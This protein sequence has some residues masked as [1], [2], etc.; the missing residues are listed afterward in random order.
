[1]VQYHVDQTVIK[2]YYEERE[3]ALA[4][5]KAKESLLK[6]F[7]AT[8]LS[9]SMLRAGDFGAPATALKLI[10]V[11][12]VNVSYVDTPIPESDA[13]PDRGVKIAIA[14]SAK[15][16]AILQ[17]ERYSFSWLFGSQDK[18]EADSTPPEI[19]QGTATWTGGIL[20]KAKVVN[21]Q[22]HDIILESLVSDEE[23]R[24]HK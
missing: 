10:S 16:T 17:K 3:N 18:T 20:A 13:A 5:V 15:C 11:D 22:F 8:H 2:P 4:T 9:E 14:L 19:F 24:T 12:S 6:E 21:R 7:L 1:M 23:L